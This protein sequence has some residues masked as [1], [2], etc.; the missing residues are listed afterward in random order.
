MKFT[1]INTIYTQKVGEYIAAG[2]TINSNTTGGSQ[3]EICKIDLR[4]GDEVIR[5]LMDTE[6]HN[7]RSSVVLVVG[8]NNDQRI[9]NNVGRTGWDTI[10]NNQ[11]EII[12]KRTF[13]QMKKRYLDVDY[14]IEG[15]AG[16]QALSKNWERAIAN[17]VDA[18]PQHVFDGVEKL[19]AKA[20]RRHLNRPGFKAQNIQKVW[21]EWNEN[22]CKYEYKAKTLKHTITLG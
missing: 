8:R 18:H 19:V 4:K 11:L 9:S 20:I 13:W 2:Y 16:E 3:G 5:V 1:D 15:V 10:W 14:Y 21:K 12:E 22:K 17:C 6:I 7:F